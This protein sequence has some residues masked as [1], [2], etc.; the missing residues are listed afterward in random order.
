M[1]VCRL[2]HGVL[3][4]PRL[5]ALS[6]PRPRDKVRGMLACTAELGGSGPE[7]ELLR[8]QGRVSPGALCP[9]AMLGRAA[10]SR[11]GPQVGRAAQ[12]WVDGGRAGKCLLQRLK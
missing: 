2:G 6:P 1:Q 10:P 7:R 3:A 4:T 12:P 8:A 9:R 5:G 11:L